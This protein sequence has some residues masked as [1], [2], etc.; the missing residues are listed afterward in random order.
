MILLHSM[1]ITWVYIYIWYIYIY[2]QYSYLNRTIIF[3]IR[4]TYCYCMNTFLSSYIKPIYEYYTKKVTLHDGIN[5]VPSHLHFTEVGPLYYLPPN[6]SIQNHTHTDAKH[7][8]LV[9]LCLHFASIT[10]VLY[11]YKHDT[12]CTGTCVTGP[13]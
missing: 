8:L 11:K 12:Y 13:S 1:N 10:F 4:E 6:L 7:A 5:I 9:D 3:D 2:P